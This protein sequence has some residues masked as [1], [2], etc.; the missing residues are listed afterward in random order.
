MLLF[1]CSVIVFVRSAFIPVMKY[2]IFP[3]DR[4]LINKVKKYDFKNKFKRRKKKK[5]KHILDHKHI[6]K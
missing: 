4:I 3:D 6:N 2:A 5:L 1:Y